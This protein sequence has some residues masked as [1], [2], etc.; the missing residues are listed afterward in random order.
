[1]PP[2]PPPGWLPVPGSERQPPPD[3][4][5]LGPVDPDEPVELTIVVRRRRPPALD[6]HRTEPLDRQEFAALAGADPRDL[7]AVAAF[8]HRFGLRIVG[9]DPA[10]RTV[11]V[12]GTL[13]SAARAFAVELQ[14]WER[15]TG[16]FRGRTGP[17]FVPGDVAEL[18]DGV[19]GLDDRI[20]ARPHF[21]LLDLAGLGP[22][23]VARHGFF[24]PEVARFYEFPDEV[25]GRG[26]TIALVELGG[27]FRRS[28]CTAAF[29]AMGLPPPD[30]V[31]IGVDGAS[32]H[33]TGDPG[34]PDGEVALDI[35]VAG[36]VAPGARIAVY[37]APNTE[38]G[39]LD[40]VASAVHDERLSPTVLSISWGGPEEAWTRQG[41]AALDA[42]FQ[43]ACAL[44]ITVCCAS[45]D[46][47]SDDR[48]G[49]GR[50]HTD[51][52]A[53]SPHVLA[54]GG[55]RLVAER[56]R[57]VEEVAWN[58]G[59]LRGATGGGV[60]AAFRLPPWQEAAG[61][62]GSANP[63]H[64]R[65]RGVPDVAG[66]AAP[67]TGYRVVVDGVARVIG[68]TSAVAPLWAGLVARCNEALGRPIG[69]LAPLLYGG[70][71]GG[72]RD[73]L[74]GD[75][76]AYRAGPGWDACTGLGS[77]RGRALLA[78]LRRLGS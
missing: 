17:V 46:D 8:A 67:A 37:F 49:D 57:I 68:G 31:V 18:V 33:P 58:A 60:S 3:G 77:P 61:I 41:L 51:F 72:V 40:A 2:S 65:G 19:F 13:G 14:R 42:V 43:D 59:P 44:G 75:N 74:A 7:A 73:I 24:A 32:N 38:R 30:V 23:A 50:A 11:T 78:C 10:R 69:W 27:G 63:G 26:E 35:Q 15:P 54:C 12:A 55:T 64:H 36:A 76:G 16:D 71:R 29:R 21:R 52:P 56:G 45:G 48:V 5:P 6:P 4:R 22:R 70:A 53:S 47:G 34:G 20:Q 25:D 9:T 28:D 66:D 1:V 39:F 62:P